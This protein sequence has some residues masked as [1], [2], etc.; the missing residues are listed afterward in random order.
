MVVSVPGLKHAQNFAEFEHISRKKYKKHIETDRQ[1]KNIAE[2]W[3]SIR[4]IQMNPGHH[5]IYIFLP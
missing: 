5:K 3:M 4:F 1:N 2:R